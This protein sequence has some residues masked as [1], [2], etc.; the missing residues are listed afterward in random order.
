[1]EQGWHHVILRLMQVRD[2]GQRALLLLMVVVVLVLVL[3]GERGK[4][5]GATSEW[6]NIDERRRRRHVR[7]PKGSQ[8]QGSPTGSIG[9]LGDPS[10]CVL[11]NSGGEVL[12]LVI[13]IVRMERDE[14]NLNENMRLCGEL[15]PG[16][17]SPAP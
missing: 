9:F 13:V 11:A 8:V 6:L 17:S 12:A 5:R 14:P 10:L 3:V 15:T 16:R 2:G 4:A 1:M 7:L